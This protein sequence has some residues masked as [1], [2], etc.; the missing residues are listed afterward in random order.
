MIEGFDGLTFNRGTIFVALI[1]LFLFG[2]FVKG[3]FS[4][5]SEP[6]QTLST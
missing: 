2:T 1:V 3:D 4:A 6:Q 5:E